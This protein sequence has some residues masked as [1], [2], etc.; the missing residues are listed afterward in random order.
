MSRHIRRNHENF[1]ANVNNY[2]I[3]ANENTFDLRLKE[4]FKMFITGPSRCGK[5]VFISQL[6][7]N[8]YNIAK[9]PP[10]KVIYVYKVWQPKFNDLLS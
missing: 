2:N 1:K 6:L 4:N 9:Q 7:E 10:A 8:I 5:T 3:Y